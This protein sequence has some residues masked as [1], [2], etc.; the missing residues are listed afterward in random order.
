MTFSKQTSDEFFATGNETRFAEW[1]LIGAVTGD[2]APVEFFTE[3]SIPS[4]IQ[5]AVGE[6]PVSVQVAFKR[7]IGTAV[8]DWMHGIHPLAA[9]RTLVL[10]A[11][12]LRV[13][14][15]VPHLAHIAR[16]QL[17][18]HLR[19]NRPDGDEL[20][21]TVG[22][23]LA[24]I[25]GFAPNQRAMVAAEALYYDDLVPS[26]YLAILL[27]AL[28][29][30]R[31]AEYPHYLPRLLR[32]IEENRTVFHVPIILDRLVQ[33]ITPAVFAEHFHELDIDLKP[34]LARL[35]NEHPNTRAKLIAG[36]DTYSLITT[37]TGNMPTIWECR[38]PEKAITKAEMSA[39]YE[40]LLESTGTD[41]VLA[42]LNM[43]MSMSNIRS[44][45]EAR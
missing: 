37:F 11:A 44:L 35:F 14:D 26:R 20:T 25:A 21:E 8:S 28:C 7:A 19:R 29:R 43:L 24:V 42:E 5:Y 6:Q 3:P 13:T 12:Y 36:E 23:L 41:D 17:I 15:L 1:L 38:L 32:K 9:L 45:M 16:S 4:Q 33:T 30:S 39:V 40:P 10:V 22:V 34:V 2:Y 27:N 31:P 18:P